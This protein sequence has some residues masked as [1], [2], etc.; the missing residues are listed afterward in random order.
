MHTSIV[1]HSLVFRWDRCPLKHWLY[2]KSASFAPS[3]PDQT[4]KRLMNNYFYQIKIHQ[5]LTSNIP[6]KSQQ[7]SLNQEFHLQLVPSTLR[8]FWLKELPSAK[9]RQLVLPI[10]LYKIKNLKIKSIIQVL[11]ITLLWV[12]HIRNI[13]I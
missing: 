11:K 9:S 4:Q 8:I 10:E 1:F 7:F 12:K 5:E 2:H 13:I 3:G 6:L